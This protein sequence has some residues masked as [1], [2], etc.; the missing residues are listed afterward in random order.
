MLYLPCAA[1]KSIGSILKSSEE[2]SCSILAR[3]SARDV[4]YNLHSNTTGSFIRGERSDTFIVIKTSG[5]GCGSE[6]GGNFRRVRHSLRVAANVAD[7]RSP[8]Y[9]QR[10]WNTCPPVMPATHK[11]K[12]LDISGLFLHLL[13][14]HWWHCFWWSK[15]TP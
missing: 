10:E 2:M 12:T 9:L 4:V 8:Q 7:A 6:E 15:V 1:R 13:F 3:L 14:P 11:Y 5:F